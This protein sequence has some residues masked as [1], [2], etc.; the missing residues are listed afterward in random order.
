MGQDNDG[1]Y[2][3][4]SKSISMSNCLVTLGLGYDWSFEEDFSKI[5]KKPIYCYDHTVNYKG[6]KKLCRK[7]IASYLFRIFKPKYVFKRN[8]LVSYIK[9][10]FCIKVIKNFFK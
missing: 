2:L 6:I 3:V 9:M 8:F 5:Y 7:F 4:E 10:F 1:G